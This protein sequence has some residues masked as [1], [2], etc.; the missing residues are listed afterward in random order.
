VKL[1]I[2]YSGVLLFVILQVPLYAQ[3]TY[4][5]DLKNELKYLLPGIGLNT[6]GLI[7]VTQVDEV[8]LSDL[9]NLDRLNV[10]S[11][12]R[13]AIDNFSSRAKLTSDVFLYSGIAVPL[14]ALTNLKCRNETKAITLM[15]LE[16]FLITTGLTGIAKG[17][18]KRYR[19]LVYNSMVPLDQKLEKAS[20]LSFFSG[21]ASVTSCLSFF[22]AKVITDL[23]PEM[24]N[25]G[26]IWTAAAAFPA[27]IGF[28]RYQAGKHFPTDV[29]SGYAIGATIGILV[30]A[31]HLKD[32]I[33]L[34]YKGNGISL[35]VRF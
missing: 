31:L 7:M 23:N 17:T 30:P 22:T 15:A 27:A 12:D 19:P 5:I 9:D 16:S 2:R 32:N 35:N 14:L 25:K 3:K 34:N 29:I 24:K 4:Q 11:F 33:K 1:H 6:L 20:R 21:H 8:T 26:L 28:F 18:S 13:G 10:N